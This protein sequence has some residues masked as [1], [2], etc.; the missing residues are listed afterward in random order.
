MNFI[1]FNYARIEYLKKVLTLK[2]FRSLFL[3]KYNT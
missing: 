2:L 1:S 3:P